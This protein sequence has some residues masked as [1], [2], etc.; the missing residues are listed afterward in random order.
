MKIERRWL[1]TV[2]MFYIYLPIFLFILGWTRLII[3]VPTILVCLFCF[4]RLFKEQNTSREGISVK[5]LVLLITAVLFILTGYYAGYGRFINQP[6][7]WAK[8]N[9]ILYDL[10]ERNWPVLYSNKGEHSMLTYYIGQYILP[11][12]A[13]KIFHSTKVAE[14]ALYIWNVV[15]IVL[16][17]LNVL[18][19]TG[20]TKVLK[21]LAYAAILPIF[22]LPLWLSEIAL[23]LLTGYNSAGDGQWFFCSDGI[24]LQYS[25]N[26]TLL[27]WV[28]P[29]TIPIWLLVIVFL[30]NKEKIKYY[31]FLLSPSLLFGTL[32]FIGIFPM[33]AVGAIKPLFTRSDERTASRVKTW[34]KQIISP[35]NVTVFISFGMLIVLYL[36]GNV[37]GEKPSSL[38]LH[39]MPYTA[40]SFALYIIFTAVLT[41]PYALILFRRHRRDWTFYVSVATLLVLPL[42]K[43]G[44]Y[45]DLTMRASIPALFLLMIY[46]IDD[47][48]IRLES[49]HSHK[50]LIDSTA[51]LLT[52]CLLVIGARY[53]LAEMLWIARS[54][55]YSA[56]GSGNE[57][58]TLEGFAN[59]SLDN[60]DEDVKFN[61]YT[62]DIDNTFFYKYI[63]K[64]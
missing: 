53:P 33:A 10:T 43:M 26:Y 38:G 35:E 44:L 57:W 6:A 14:I 56:L 54:D 32:T 41:L 63:T 1:F 37:T 47:F 11:S 60:V 31:V 49:L 62:Y 2:S 45:N 58:T 18:L 24:Q 30:L 13:G 28:F 40:K 51:L 3:A 25:N 55:D 15:G 16:V 48:F 61:Y 59:R 52:L 12:L 21:Q 20:A 23:K 9:A 36:F 64:K 39:I 27:K 19:Y 29:Q 4:Y 50:T 17:Y 7:D 5:F 42:F 22:S 34:L 8:H 46:I